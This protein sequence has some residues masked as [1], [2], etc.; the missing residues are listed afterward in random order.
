MSVSTGLAA[1]SG[2]ELLSRA[3]ASAPA[4]IRPN[5]SNGVEHVVVLM[6]E[7]RSF[8]HFLGWLPGVVH[9]GPFEHTSTLK[10]IE[11]T[12]G[13][14]PMTARDAHAENLGQVLQ[15]GPRR[16]VPAGAIPT[17]AQ[18]LGPVSDA[19]AMCGAGSVRST[20]P[21]PVHHGHGPGHHLDGAVPSTVPQQ[22]NGMSA[23]GRQFRDSHG[24]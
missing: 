9:H 11:S 4:G 23:F 14:R 22:V 2:T 18:V 21:A 24:K 1:V 19:A 17:S 6:M 15:R 7:N 8:D 10:M 3:A 13:L 16:P 5:G 12:F 20:S